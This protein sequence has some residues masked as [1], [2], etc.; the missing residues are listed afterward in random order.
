MAWVAR[1]PF[2]LN[3]LQSGF[4]VEVL[5][6]SSSVDVVI[7]AQAQGNERAEPVLLLDARPTLDAPSLPDGP[8]VLEPLPDV[9]A[10]PLGLQLGP[11]PPAAPL[12][13]AASCHSSTSRSCAQPAAVTSTTTRRQGK[14][15]NVLGQLGTLPR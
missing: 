2:P 7:A 11:H 14:D 15:P 4:V 9:P 10:L 3:G 6:S 8:A 1:A 12:P 5:K 13:F